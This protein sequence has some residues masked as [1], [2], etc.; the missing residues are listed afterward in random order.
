VERESIKATQTAEKRAQLA[1][2]RVGLAQA[3][4]LE[5]QR[6]VA[7]THLVL[8]RVD[9]VLTK[10]YRKELSA[11]KTEEVQKVL[12]DLR[13]LIRKNQTEPLKVDITV[14]SVNDGSDG[15]AYEF[16]ST[17]AGASVYIVPRSEWIAMGFVE[18]VTEAQLE[19]YALPQRTPT[20]H[21]MTSGTYVVVLVRDTS[22][23][24]ADVRVGE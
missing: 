14:A 7:G 1:E 16:R 19:T 8:T 18:N 24:R 13:E 5:S 11:D 21:A 6:R 20:Q 22:W 9:D 15:T 12:D 10:V 3:R 4:E 2:E 23:H 17:P